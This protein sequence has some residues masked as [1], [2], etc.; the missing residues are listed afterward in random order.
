LSEAVGSVYRNGCQVHGAIGQS[1]N[2]SRRQR[3]VRVLALHHDQDPSRRWLARRGAVHIANQ[4]IQSAH[5]NPKRDA[6]MRL[7]PMRR[8]RRPQRQECR[9]PAVRSGIQKSRPAV[10]RLSRICLQVKGS[11]D[12][13][14]SSP[15]DSHGCTTTRHRCF[16][17]DQP[18]EAVQDRL[19]T[20]TVC[21]PHRRWKQMQATSDI[22]EG[23][24][25]R[26]V[27]PRPRQVAGLNCLVRDQPR[28]PSVQPLVEP[29]ATRG[30]PGGPCGSG[31]PG[32][33]YW[34][35]AEAACRSWDGWRRSQFREA[36]RR[37][38]RCI[39]R[40]KRREQLCQGFGPGR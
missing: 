4:R 13:S 35:V 40:R 30:I 10:D 15:G 22:Y 9:G 7:A 37:R 33:A 2:W 32:Q 5:L 16:A 11:S 3:C 14:R 38:R 31:G 36:A 27:A 17:L 6:T 1:T 23:K 24:P 21:E 29:A 18:P 28:A 12:R 26:V 19:L 8:D 20:G 39:W 34:A 25:V